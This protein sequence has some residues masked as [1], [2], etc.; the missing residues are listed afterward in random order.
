MTNN[1]DFSEQINDL[2]EDLSL[3]EAENLIES[4]LKPSKDDQRKEVI[5]KI[6]K[7]DIDLDE[8]ILSELKE[9]VDEETGDDKVLEYLRNE[10]G[11]TIDDDVPQEIKEE[12]ETVEPPQE[13]IYKKDQEIETVLPTQTQKEDYITSLTD[14]FGNYLADKG[15]KQPT[16]ESTEGLA[17]KLEALQSQFA[18]LK[19]TMMEGTLVSG[20]GQGGDG[21]GPGSGEV[22]I[23]RM[24]DVDLG[25]DGIEGLEEGDALVWDPNANGGHGAWVPG[26]PSGGG[27]GGNIQDP[28]TGDIWGCKKVDGPA[29]LYW[30]TEKDYKDWYV[31][32]NDISTTGAKLVST[33]GKV[34][35]VTGCVAFDYGP[36]TTPGDPPGAMYSKKW[37]AIGVLD[38]NG[39]GLGVEISTDGINPD[40]G[41]FLYYDKSLVQCV[42]GIE[43]FPCQEIPDHP[44]SCMK[45]ESPGSTL[46][47]GTKAEMDASLGEPVQDAGGLAITNCT[48]ILFQCFGGDPLDFNVDRNGQFKVLYKIEG[49][50]QPRE[51]EILDISPDSINGAFYILGGVCDNP[52]VPPQPPVRGCVA[53]TGCKEVASTPTTIGNLMWGDGTT[54]DQVQDSSGIGIANCRKIY[55]MT[56]TNTPGVTYTVDPTTG[57]ITGSWDIVYEDFLGN[58]YTAT[59]EGTCCDVPPCA[60]GFYIDSTN[61]C[62]NP[63]DVEEPDNIPCPGLITGCIESINGDGALYWGNGNKSESVP[64]LESPGGGTVEDVKKLLYVFSVDF[65]DCSTADVGQWMVLYKNK[66]DKLAVGWSPTGSDDGSVEGF[67]LAD[68]CDPSADTELPDPIFGFFPGCRDSGTGDS[69]VFWGRR[70][71]YENAFAGNPNNG[72][73]VQNLLGANITD[74]RKLWRAVTFDGIDEWF[75]VVSKDTG[76]DFAHYPGSNPPPVGRLYSPPFGFYLIGGD[77]SADDQEQLDCR[78]DPPIELK[79]EGCQK[80]G[81]TGGNLIWGK[82]KDFGTATGEQV[83]TG[84]Q[85]LVSITSENVCDNGFGKWTA[86]YRPASDPTALGVAER[87]GFN[88]FADDDDESDVFWLELNGQPCEE[89]ATDEIDDGKD[90]RGILLGC[91]RT[92][93]IGGA[94]LFWGTDENDISGDP[95]IDVEGNP[96]ID[97]KFIIGNISLNCDA[98]GFG[99]WICIFT[100]VYNKTRTAITYGRSGPEGYYLDPTDCDLTVDDCDGQIYFGYKA[101]CNRLTNLDDTATDWGG[102]LIWTTEAGGT[103]PIKDISNNT[104]ITRNVLRTFTYDDCSDPSFDITTPQSWS[105]LH[106]NNL[107]IL[108]VDG[109]ET[110]ESPTD[111]YAIDTSGTP[112]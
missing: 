16:P 68:D 31:L 102:A 109:A 78:V 83:A 33:P 58:T 28:L 101:D 18:A 76:I 22:R 43:D 10:M 61:A 112:R 25:P 48:E 97:A 72:Q 17:A 90:C 65:S 63:P 81:G 3:D 34:S 47:W 87:Y 89:E 5:D 41:Y 8:K 96:V 59:H 52:P 94:K 75:S 11:L 74:A 92:A 108:S 23:N 56:A 45:V 7:N 85:E 1:K 62:L 21:Q 82:K 54:G 57:E 99:D 70:D 38:E 40:E 79:P 29:D 26:D 88:P 2:F 6:T 60:T 98:S 104:V 35:S 36:S 64:A 49:S 13:T 42:E 84:V 12:L 9:G 107:G 19:S 69:Q 32:G 105:A 55:P 66:L 15:I 37:V 93:D 24:D 110:G 106:F 95:V 77:C 53:E 103:K 27:P 39:I 80:V 51:A 73:P 46:M 67:F 14:K 30:G 71:D 86:T 20:I 44:D 91:R 100:D 50:K 111:G 4:E